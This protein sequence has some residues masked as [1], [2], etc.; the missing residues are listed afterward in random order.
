MLRKK[1]LKGMHGIYV[2]VEDLGPE[3]KGGLNPK[4]GTKTSGDATSDCWDSRR[5][6]T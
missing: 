2:V 4:C 5:Q 1:S 3:L 6:G